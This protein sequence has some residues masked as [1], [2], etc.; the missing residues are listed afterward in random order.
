MILIGSIIP[1]VLLLNPKTGKS[2]RWI[3]VS[4]IMVVIGVLC[5][6]YLIVIPGLTHAP[7]ILPNMVITDS[8]F[9]EG[10]VTYWISPYELVEAIGILGLI[11]FMFVAG[12]KFFK[13]LPTEARIPQE[14]ASSE[15]DVTS[16]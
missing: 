6:R 11:G 4:S 16:T 7:D 5:E 14:V 2:I 8:P 9:Q 12:L 1:A 13:M 15:S 10:N 3:V